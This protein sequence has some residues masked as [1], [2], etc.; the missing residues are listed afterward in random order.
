MQTE[1]HCKKSTMHVNSAHS[2]AFTTKTIIA[3][4][5]VNAVG[6]IA[7]ILESDLL[8]HVK[9]LQVIQPALKYL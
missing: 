3:R 1:V 7:N 5:F 8:K 6:P 4:L 2:G 9:Y